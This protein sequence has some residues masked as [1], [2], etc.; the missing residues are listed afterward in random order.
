MKKLAILLLI[1][2]LGLSLTGATCMQNVQNM[3]CNPPAAV[4]AII[5]PAAPII[6]SILNIAIPGTS[7][8]INAANAQGWINTIQNT[9]CI[10][11]TDLN[12]LIAY[13]QGADFTQ[14]QAI[15]AKAQIAKGFLAAPIPKKINVA[16]LVDWAATAK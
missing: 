8:F 5:G 2:G 10:S 9:G 7:V 12:N 11:L 3:V 15:V 13:F 6:A 16:P 1:I 14:G 4:M